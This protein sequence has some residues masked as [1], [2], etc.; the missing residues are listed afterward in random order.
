MGLQKYAATTANCNRTKLSRAVAQFI[1]IENEP[2]LAGEMISHA[3]SA[4]FEILG[5][6]GRWCW[7][8]FFC[9]L[10]W[11]AFDVQRS[12][13]ANIIVIVPRRYKP[14]KKIICIT[15]LAGPNGPFQISGSEINSY[16]GFVFSQFVEHDEWMAGALN[17]LPSYEFKHHKFQNTL[18]TG[19]CKTYASRISVHRGIRSGRI[20]ICIFQDIYGMILYIYKETDMHV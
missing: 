9:V 15:W 7:D 3:V 19:F 10:R 5:C 14:H 18:L 12:F 2:A 11:G 6:D 8:V 1:F 20:S 16:V 4:H 13:Y 17:R